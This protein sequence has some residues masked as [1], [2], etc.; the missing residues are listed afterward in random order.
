VRYSGWCL[1]CSLVIIVVSESSLQAI[2]AFV[3]ILAIIERDV[4][5]SIQYVQ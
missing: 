4:Q 1:L 2:V 5:C 3:V